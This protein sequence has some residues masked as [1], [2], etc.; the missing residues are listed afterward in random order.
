[1]DIFLYTARK[2]NDLHMISLLATISTV[3]GCGVLP[4]GQ[5]STR[6]F[7]VT[8]F[9]LPVAMVY[10]TA[11]DVQVQVPGIATSEAGAIG[12]VQRLV[13]QTVFDVLES[14]ARTALLPDAVISAILNQLTVR[15]TYA[16]LMCSKVRLSLMNADPRGYSILYHLED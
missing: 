13:M 14:Q 8:G 1:M 5:G 2:V 16:P 11:P 9:A 7:N 6:N 12:F 3:F 10:S 4:S 15:V